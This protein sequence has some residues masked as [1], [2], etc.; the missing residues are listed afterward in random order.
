[1][2]SFNKILSFL[3][4]VKAILLEISNQSQN[5]KTFKEQPQSLL[6]GLSFG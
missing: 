3:K 1:M 4:K 6:F 2:V 5:L